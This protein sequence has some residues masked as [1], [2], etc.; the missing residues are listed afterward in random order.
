LPDKKSQHGRKKEQQT[1]AK[2]SCKTDS[3]TNCKT[4][5][6]NSCSLRSAAGAGRIYIL[7]NS[8]HV[9]REAAEN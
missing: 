2:A 1:T 7:H 6:S 4:S 5:A 8:F 3:K 9:W